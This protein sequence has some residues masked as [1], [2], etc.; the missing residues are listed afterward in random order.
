MPTRVFKALASLPWT[1]RRVSV[2]VG[3]LLIGAGAVYAIREWQATQLPVGEAFIQED[4]AIREQLLREM[5]GKSAPSRVCFLAFGSDDPPNEFVARLA[6]LGLTFRKKSDIV[7][8]PGGT[9]LDKETGKQGALYSVQTRWI[10][11]REVEVDVSEHSAMLASRGYKGKM[12]KTNGKWVL[13]CKASDI[14]IS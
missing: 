7:M 13:E 4:F 10:N 8:G 11:G 9:N 5:I 1:K 14:W 6:D 2:A 12:T 3:M